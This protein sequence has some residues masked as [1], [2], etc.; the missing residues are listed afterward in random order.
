MT[1]GTV[2]PIEHGKKPSARDQAIEAAGQAQKE[3]SERKADKLLTLALEK[4]RPG[5]TET[6]SPMAVP[7]DGAPLAIIV[8]D[9]MGDT[10][11]DDLAHLSYEHFA[12]VPAGSV[13]S[14]VVRVW[15]VKG[16]ASDPERVL[17][18]IGYMTD[19]SHLVYDLGRSD[20]KAVAIEP[21]AWLVVDD[22]GLTV[23]RRT[24]VTKPQVI[25][26][27]SSTPKD[28]NMMLDVLNLSNVGWQVLR[29]LMVVSLIPNVPKPIGILTGEPG[30][31]KSDATKFVLRV[32]DPQAAE[33][34]PPP[35]SMGDLLVSGDASMVL[36]F[37]NLSAIDQDLSDAMCRLATGAGVR[38]RSLYTDRNLAVFDQMR[39]V[40]VNGIELSE[41][42]GDFVDRAVPIQLLHIPD[43]DR[44]TEET[45]Q[46]RFDTLLPRILGGLFSTIAQAWAIM[47]K[48]QLRTLPRMADAAMWF[49]A[50][51]AVF[52]D[53][54]V[55][56]RSLELLTDSKKALFEAIVESD[57]LAMA[58][59]SF[60]EGHGG[61]TWTGTASDLKRHLATGFDDLR[62]LPPTA[63]VLGTKLRA[64]AMPLREAG[65][66][67]ITFDRS[68]P[69][70][71]IDITR[72]SRW[73]D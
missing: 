60:M 73:S 28:L 65:F 5:K 71:T 54:G 72:L 18:R 62:W 55:E 43:E 44:M 30:S 46:A 2:S 17:L 56:S 13:L 33:L 14:D 69:E 9:R 20:H 16:R 15:A 6:G 42:R 52:Q 4:W 10:F 40:L 8:G 38:N 25:P 35:K 59:V 23:F 48:I 26:E 66:L 39:A 45:I 49:A 37:D 57:E 41:L 64:S 47:P 53:L 32:V 36:A 29:S 21:G 67:D 24:S 51:D 19:T 34:Q 50:V 1:D 61:D 12:E 63:S 68:G 7:L 3:V 58:V 11:K 27:A 22:L 70:R 31:G